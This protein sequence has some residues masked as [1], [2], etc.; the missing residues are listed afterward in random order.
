[1]KNNF[2][3]PQSSGESAWEKETRNFLTWLKEEKLL[4]EED[5]EKSPED[6]VL[7]PYNEYK[8]EFLARTN[9]ESEFVRETVEFAEWLKAKSLLTEEDGKKRLAGV[10]LQNYRASYWEAFEKEKNQRG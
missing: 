10:D 1:M 3:T 8:N 9:K 4:K 5:V 6:I 2:E 7:T